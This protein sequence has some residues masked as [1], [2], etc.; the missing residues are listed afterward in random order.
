MFNDDDL[1][2]DFIIESREHLSD[3]ENQLLTIEAGGADIDV[4]LVNTVFRA[5]HSIKGASG[6]F[7]LAVIGDLAHRLENVL[8]LF[9]ERKLVP[10]SQI[11]DAALKASDRLRTLIEDVSHSNEQNVDEHLAVLDVI[12]D[13]VSAAGD[14]AASAPPPTAAPVDSAAAPPPVEE[15]PPEASPEPEV[16]ATASPAEPPPPP[17]AEPTEARES[18][19]AKA[20]VETSIR[21]SIETLDQLM[22]LAGEL[23]LGRNQL[24]QTVSRSSMEG[25]ES[26]AAKINQ[27]TS[28]MQDAIMQ[29]RMQ[30]IGNV[31]N[32]FPRVV[33][34]LS[35]KLGKQ[36][37]LE[38]DGNDV[39][40]D[41]TIVEAIGDPLTHLIRNAV[42]HG[43][44]TPD[45]RAAAGKVGEG[46]IRL[47]AAH[48]SGKVCIEIQDDGAGIDTHR[49]KAKALERGLITP[50]QVAQMSDRDAARLIFHAGFSTAEKIS[51]VSGRG[52]GMDVV[53][54]NIE[55]LGGSVEI[56]SEHGSGTMIRITLPLTLAIIPSLIVG[57]GA[58]RFAIPQ[59]NIAELVRV[60]AE[61]AAGRIG[62]V[63]EREVL[64]LRGSLL[65]LLRLSD[66]LGVGQEQPPA[67][68]AINAYAINVIVVESGQQRY[69]L[70]V[71]ALHDSEEIVVKPLGRHLK[72]CRCLSGATI[73]GDGH[74]ALILDVPGIAAHSDLQ[75]ITDAS[76][77]QD[78][79][80][81]DASRSCEKHS[82]LLFTN[83]PRD[84]FAIP[85]SLVAR[86][87]RI[88]SDQVDSVGGRLL[89]QYRGGTLPLIALEDVVTARPRPDA[90]RLYVI[91]FS[92]AGGEVG[93]IAPQLDDIR[94]VDADVDV[95]SLSQPG[96]CGTFVID[97]RTTRLLEVGALVAGAFPERAAATADGG[98]RSPEG[99]EPVRPRVLLAEDSGFFRKQV[100]RF[101][102]DSGCDVTSC[103]DGL[104]AWNTL[105]SMEEEFDLIVTDIEM[106][107]MN[108]LEFCRNVKDDPRFASLPVIALTSLASEEDVRRG[109]EQGIDEY[110][111]KMDRE[112]L[113]EA[114]RRLS[115]VALSGRLVESL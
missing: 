95:V 84:H 8:N 40:V 110:Q 9:R 62:R 37:R 78:G 77:S 85:M 76:S 105:R 2:D 94:D 71:D 29:T 91:V 31:F 69:G 101:L 57:C 107:N 18:T 45:V 70:I 103:E 42:D 96:V 60:R 82:V 81:H 41:K 64:R 104:V 22:N 28:E 83:D 27:V 113:V 93:L 15:A 3:V 80:S 51:D 108:G 115:A 34:D 67:G 14:E 30:P 68:S 17:R 112:R 20:P 33:R 92:N 111:V 21:V 66:V 26:V 59:L 63:K 98:R 43:L 5:V 102:D 97:Q 32:R 54:T 56:E 72:D 52:V 13:G 10:N 90:D 109:K 39:E 44:E 53:R 74:V 99:Q 49:V 58:D 7:G 38:V 79:S 46:V 4:D 6:F 16:S 19:A 65:P 50:E 35:N 88:R 86:I 55:R 47:R 61:D 23:V 89:L 24:L 87:E 11:I 106:P 48:K 12:A 25:L 1:L 36:C 73:L 114:V 100:A 75:S